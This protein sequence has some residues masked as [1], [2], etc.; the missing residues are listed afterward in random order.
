MSNQCRIDVE[1]M[2]NRPV[3]RGGR[4]R[5]EGG[6]S[7]GPVPNKPLT[8]FCVIVEEPILSEIFCPKGAT[9][10]NKGASNLGFSWGVTWPSSPKWPKE[11]ENEPISIYSSTILT[12]FWL[13][14]DFL[15]LRGGEVPGTHF[16]LFW[17]LWA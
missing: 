3:R 13:R 1:S 4:G 8:K 11:F 10:G 2:P 5:F 17:L 9:W 15:D 6:V 12:L 14:F 16:G 7:L